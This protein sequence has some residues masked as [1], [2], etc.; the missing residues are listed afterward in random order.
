MAPTT[1]PSRPR[2]Y[3]VSEQIVAN[4]VSAS[5]RHVFHDCMKSLKNRSLNNNSL[6]RCYFDEDE[7]VADYKPATDYKGKALRL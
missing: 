3:E 7:A 4:A 1:L 6:K 5:S 2:Q